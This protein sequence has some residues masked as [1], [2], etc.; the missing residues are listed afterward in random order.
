M[1]SKSMR[2]RLLDVRPDRI[3]LRDRIYNPPLRSLPERYPTSKQINQ[4]LPRYRT[5]KMILD[6]GH[7]G[8]CSGFGLAATINFVYWKD[9]LGSRGSVQ[10]VSP[11]MLYHLARIYDEWP[12][13]DY[14]GSSCRGA[15]K[16]WHRH[17]VC[18]EALWPYRNSR[19]AVCF[20]KP[21]SGWIQDAAQRPLG[22]YYRINKDS[23]ADMQAAVNEVGAIF[24]SADVHDGWFIKKTNSL[25][26]IQPRHGDTGGHAFAIVGYTP[27]GFIVQNSWGPD[28]GYNGFAVLPY[29]DW[30]EHGM[31]AWV[32][33]LGAPV[34]LPPGTA[35]AALR[36]QSLRDV[37]DGRATWFWR[38]DRTKRPYSY[39]NK[40]VE[41][42]GETDAYRHSVVL[43]NDGRP[44]NR[45]LETKDAAA[46]LR[47]V[48]FTH[49]RAWLR[50]THTA[51]LAIYAHGGL[52]NEEAS[53]K[54][55]RVLAPYF[56]A[57]GIYPIFLTWRTGAL[58]SILEI[59]EDSANALIRPEAPERA[60]GIRDVTKDALRVIR[61]A[62]DRTF[63]EAST[64]LGIK[65]IWTQ[66]KQN[67]DAAAA[68]GGG[69]EI[70]AQHLEELARAVAGLEIHL[71]GHSAG[72]I[73]LG[74]LVRLLY[75]AGRRVQTV[76]L[77]APAC[78][79]RF[80]LDHYRGDAPSRPILPPDR[81]HC[82]IMNDE[83]ERADSVGL[84][85]K[86]LLYLVSRALEDVHKMPLLGMEVAWPTKSG[87][88]LSD[89]VWAKS[90]QSDLEEWGRYCGS[91]LS[92]STSDKSREQVSTGSGTTRL[93]HGSFDN[94][95][96]VI[97]RTLERILG[98]A[99]QFD[100]EN[101]EGF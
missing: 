31:D 100:V 22:A 45:L 39:R 10:K 36:S 13:E 78:T 44:L 50:R 37:A 71:V 51:K 73:I 8:A 66:M 85:G 99:L 29:E 83:R 7:E 69:I 76:T 97:S 72:S 27:E 92:P 5:Q 30:I 75:K 49:P 43:G 6:Q 33:V 25:A 80:A 54:R 62:A 24:V 82:E 12:G 81:L 68:S 70:L 40:E 57:N 28:W 42:W 77:F 11:R 23:V 93:A 94:D 84:Y 95:V 35:Q 61:E 86:S 9:A 15:M 88:A 58:D 90:K 64:R 16:G 41:P 74:H 32:A 14:E 38:S 89:N 20:L 1:P 65:A 2:G 67:A 3:D 87:F 47:E 101:L 96:V 19:G 4:F 26:L 48:A 63:E 46:L 79:L 17:G 91:K 56:R 53:V 55:I 59:A 34:A 60:E 52:N 18:T 98:N 21:K